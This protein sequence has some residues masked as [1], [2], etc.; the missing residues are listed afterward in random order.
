MRFRNAAMMLM[1]AGIEP[2]SA[3][4]IGV[5]GRTSAGKDSDDLADNPVGHT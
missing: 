4:V 3:T 2:V 5:S 1:S